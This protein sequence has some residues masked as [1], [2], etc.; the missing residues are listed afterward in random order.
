MEN[1]D[2]MG[3]THDTKLATLQAE[4]SQRGQTF[5]ATDIEYNQ[6]R[7]LVT[8]LESELEILLKDSLS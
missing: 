1:F 6:L 8:S 2:E 5:S 3:R 4:F 7:Y